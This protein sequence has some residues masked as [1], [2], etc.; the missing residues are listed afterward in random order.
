MAEATYKYKTGRQTHFDKACN[1][2]LRT[3]LTDLGFQL[4]PRVK[5]DMCEEH[6]DIFKQE[7]EEAWK[8][9]KLDDVKLLLEPREVAVVQQ[10]MPT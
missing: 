10:R 6:A 7:A 2:D 3:A 1:V 9:S 4:S 8:S 5:P